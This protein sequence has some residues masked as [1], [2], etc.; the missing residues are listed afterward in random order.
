MSALDD[1]EP[2]HPWVRDANVDGVFAQWQPRYAEHGVA[3]FPVGPNKRPLMTNWG[4]VGLPASAILARKKFAYADAFAYR[5]GKRSKVTVADVDSTDEKLVAQTI[6]K[7]GQ[8]GII[9]RTASG[10][11]HLLYRWNGERRRIRPWGKG[12]PIDILGEGKGQGG[13]AIAAPSRVDG[14]QYAIIHGHL[15]DLNRLPVGVGLDPRAQKATA[16]NSPLRGMVEHDGRNDVLFRIIGPIA[17]DINLAGGTREQLLAIAR[18]HNE[19][20]AEPMQEGEV[21]QTVD[22]VWGLTLEGRNYIGRPGAFVDVCDVDRMIGNDQDALM[23]LMWLRSRQRPQAEF[24]C[25][26]GL[27]KRLGWGEDRVGRARRRLIERG[28]IKPVR[29]AGRGNPALFRWSYPY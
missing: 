3:T 11:F 18:E 24:M 5:C 2:L 6:A 19:Q 26:N 25:A 13:Y 20:C 23:L 29:K 8:P 10:K 12:L 16:A 17:R 28:Y 9:T 7:H 27:G 15:D 22:S 4:R 1:D 21:M 14:G